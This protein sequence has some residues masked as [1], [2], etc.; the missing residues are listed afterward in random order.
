[1]RAA[2]IIAFICG[3]LMTPAHAVD[4]STIRSYV[5]QYGVAKAIRWALAQ[6]YTWAQIK[7]ARAEC[8]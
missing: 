8:K 2:I 6:G 4:C 3:V 1:M 7:A 5:A